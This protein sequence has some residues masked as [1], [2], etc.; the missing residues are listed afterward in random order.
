MSAEQFL[1]QQ[2]LELRDQ[3][4]AL[5]GKLYA[6]I[7][8]C[9]HITDERDAIQVKLALAVAM[10]TPLLKD[11]PYACLDGDCG[12]EWEVEPKPCP[13]CT[14]IKEVLEK[15]NPPDRPTPEGKK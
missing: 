9:D 7:E 10:L 6:F 15:L 4:V 13:A 12:A 11:C 1:N 5:M 8:Q 3:R 14:P 2:I